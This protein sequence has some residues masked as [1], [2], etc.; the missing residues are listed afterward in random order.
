M[1]TDRFQFREMVALFLESC[2]STH[3]DWRR[4]T[5]HLFMAEG[6]PRLT[7]YRTIDMVAQQV[8]GDQLEK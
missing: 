6:Q 1:V 7:I 2:R 4:L 5:V 8:L 3:D